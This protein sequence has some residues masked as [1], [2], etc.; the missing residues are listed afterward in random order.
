MKASKVNQSK[1]IQSLIIK[2]ESASNVM[3]YTYAC[4]ELLMLVGEKKFNQIVK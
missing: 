3:E 2:I 4:S 1:K